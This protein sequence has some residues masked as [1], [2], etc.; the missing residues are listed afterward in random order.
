M[1]F[2]NHTAVGRALILATILLGG[3]ATR[4][5]RGDTPTP[6]DE[7]AQEP[8]LTNANYSSPSDQQKNYKIQVG[9]DLAIS[10]YL[11]SEFDTEATVRPDGRIGMRLVGDQQARGLTPEQLSTEL[12]EAYSTELR[13]PGVSVLVK[14]SPSRVAYVNGQ[15]DH[16]GVVP[17]EPDMTAVEAITVAGGFSDGADPNSVVLIRRDMCGQP[18]GLELKLGKVIKKTN[19]DYQ[20]DAQL[21]PGDV[22]VVPRSGIA[23]VG[24]FVKQYMRDVMP[25]QPYLSMMPF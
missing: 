21:L 20:E 10:F 19:P 2:S 6:R 16:P 12:D 13:Q 25:I 23:N 7:I 9:D 22:L 5:T 24:L 4:D 17:L 3:C 14:N 11:N 15:V 8:C 1:S 18:H